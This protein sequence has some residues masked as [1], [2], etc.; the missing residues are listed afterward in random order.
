ML[1]K[2]KKL[3]GVILF[4]AALCIA[5]NMVFLLG[6]M[7]LGWYLYVREGLAG[8]AG[9]AVVS[10]KGKAPEEI[11]TLYLIGMG[12]PDSLINNIEVVSTTVTLA[13]PNEKA[14]RIEISLPLDQTLLF[15]GVPSALGMTSETKVS[16]VAYM[17]KPQ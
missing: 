8:A 2:R 9:Q 7:E 16:A 15:G 17:R 5:L 13:F 14:D 6:G 1:F 4:E 3:R 10:T 11:A 12:L